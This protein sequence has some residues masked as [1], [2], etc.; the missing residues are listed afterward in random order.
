MVGFVL[1]LGNLGGG[2][3]VSGAPSLSWGPAL[4][5]DLGLLLAF[6]GHHSLMARRP[7]KALL[8]QRIG[9]TNERSLYVL[10]AGLLLVALVEFWQPIGPPLWVATGALL[11]ILRGLFALGWLLAIVGS[12]QLDHRRLFG[13]RPTL[14]R[15][16]KRGEAP[17]G[18]VTT[19]V[20]AWVRHPIYLGTS[21]AMWSTPLGTPGHLVLASVLCG[22]ILFGMRLEE[23]DLADEHGA[24][25]EQ[26]LV[27]TPALLPQARRTTPNTRRTPP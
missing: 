5:I 18:L 25:F 13:F 14:Q 2:S 9:P 16:V 20:Y 4:A 10:V 8:H 19:G 24:Q 23:R 7:V 27:A 12:W 11:W 22:Y 15:L 1:F 26:W 17:D 6:C 3:T 21:V